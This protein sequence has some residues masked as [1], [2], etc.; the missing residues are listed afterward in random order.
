MRVLASITMAIMLAA[1]TTPTRSHQ[2]ASGW[3]YPFE[4][5]SS[6]D[7]ARID[8]GAVRESRS[9]FVV[10]IA[11]GRHP[12]WPKERRRP[13]ILE[14]PYQKARQSPDGLWHLCI[15]DAGELLCFFSPGGDS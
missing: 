10:T 3:D 14:I 2:A 8:A 1:G 4:C 11:P 9:G 15:N 12:M 5:C 6:A 13:L 7:C